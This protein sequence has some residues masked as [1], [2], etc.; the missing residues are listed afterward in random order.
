M[1]RPAAGS[2]YVRRADHERRRA[3]MTMKAQILVNEQHEREKGRGPS[4]PRFLFV[5]DL[6]STVG[7]GRGQEDEVLH[8]GNQEEKTHIT[9]CR[10]RGWR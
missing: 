5:D 7:E 8:R 1:L 3:V 10:G 2:R 6:A 4:H 9:Y